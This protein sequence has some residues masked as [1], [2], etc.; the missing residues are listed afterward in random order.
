MGW[1]ARIRREYYLFKGKCIARLLKI[2]KKFLFYWT[3]IHEDHRKQFWRFV[4]TGTEFLFNAV[5]L[6]VPFS[7]LTR[8]TYFQMVLCVW[9]SLPFIEHYYVFFMEKW[10]DHLL[11]R[12]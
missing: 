11:E 10:K 1:K 7:I 5:L 6:A 4:K 3:K 8:Y 9:F 2:R 12:E